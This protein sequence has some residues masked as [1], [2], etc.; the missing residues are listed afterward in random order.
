MARTAYPVAFGPVTHATDDGPRPQYP[1]EPPP[2]FVMPQS[3]QPAGSVVVVEL[4][5]VDVVVVVT[6]VGGSGSGSRRSHRTSRHVSPAKLTAVMSPNPAPNP[7]P[8][9]A[10]VPVWKPIVAVHAIG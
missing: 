7:S 3:I 5:V 1:D 8:G 6:V 4:V 10:N 2:A 9:V